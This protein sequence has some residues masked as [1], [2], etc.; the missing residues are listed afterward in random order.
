MRCAYP[1][2]NQEPHQH[3][4]SEAVDRKD[5]FFYQADD[6]NYIPRSVLLD[7]EPR[8]VDTMFEMVEIKEDVRATGPVSGSAQ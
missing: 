3:A 1:S 6:D 8:I 2:R 4:V 5:V 7:L